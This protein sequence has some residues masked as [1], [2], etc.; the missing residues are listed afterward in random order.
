MANIAEDVNVET[1]AVHASA[2]VSK[3]RTELSEARYNYL[4]K[5]GKYIMSNP[6][7]RAAKINEIRFDTNFE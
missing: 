1:T 3:M 2:L 7:A 6:E 5:H 4:K